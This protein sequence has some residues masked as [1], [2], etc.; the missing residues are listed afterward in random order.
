MKI[1]KPNGEFKTVVKS[2]L[3]RT[4]AAELLAASPAVVLERIARGA[5]MTR[6]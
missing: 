4:K 3:A 5:G 2:V 1:A 6:W